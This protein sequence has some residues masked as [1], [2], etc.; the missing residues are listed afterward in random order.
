M[1][2]AF[3]VGSSGFR[4]IAACNGKLSIGHCNGDI[5][6][7]SIEDGQ[8]LQTLR[9]HEDTV[10]YLRFVVENKL[11]SVC[12]GDLICEWDLTMESSEENADPICTQDLYT[13]SLPVAIPPN[14]R[15]AA[16][17]SDIIYEATIWLW[18][19]EGYK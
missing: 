11:V 9:Q 8:H 1:H 19:L 3:S 2:R 10:R 12:D 6:L 17:G 16:I 13:F 18:P 7:W 15:H 5:S 14:G 4:S